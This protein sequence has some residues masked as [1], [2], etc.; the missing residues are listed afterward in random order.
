MLDTKMSYKKLRREYTELLERLAVNL[1]KQL[2]HHNL[3]GD[4]NKDKQGV[5]YVI[6][7]VGTNNYKIG[8]ST[9]YSER[10]NLFNVKLPFEIAETAV[11][12]TDNFLEKEKELH[13]FFAEKRLNG[14]EFFELSEEDLE[15]IP[16]IIYA[17]KDEDSEDVEGDS[18][19]SPDEI[20][21]EQAKQAI[22]D[23]PD[24][25]STSFLQRKLS[26]GYSR[27]ARMID[28][29][30]EEGF[31]GPAEGSKPRKIISEPSEE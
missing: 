4:K 25:A 20:L 14:S 23:N 22:L 17:E 12:E 8:V 7:Q 3:S 31:L 26:I 6:N 24:K 28:L 27:A 1:I 15:M 10:L 30:E 11:Y 5:V 9:N 16:E 2:E 18:K 19:Q 29:L 21:L 13:E